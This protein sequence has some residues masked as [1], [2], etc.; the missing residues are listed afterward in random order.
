MSYIHCGN[1]QCDFSQDDFWSLRFRPQWKFWRWR[2]VFGYNPVT[3]MLEGIG[4]YIRPRWIGFDSHFVSG[5]ERDHGFRLRTRTVR[6]SRTIEYGEVL[7]G[8]DEQY[9]GLRQWNEVQV[10]SWSMLRWEIYRAIL[11]FKKMKWWTEKSYKRDKTKLCPKCGQYISGA[12][13]D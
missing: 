8:P 1:R 5:L 13:I 6:R 3:C 7:S 9:G 4:D 11:K 12:N 2:T 10:F